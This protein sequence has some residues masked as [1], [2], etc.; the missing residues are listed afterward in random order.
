M[1]PTVDFYA[2]QILGLLKSQIEIKKIIF[3]LIGILV[4]FRRH[5]LQ[6]ENLAKLIFLNK[7][8]PYD[9]KIGYKAPSSLVDLIETVQI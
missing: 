2:K 9:S 4:N 8:W 1:F 6:L 5:H 7:N 3:S